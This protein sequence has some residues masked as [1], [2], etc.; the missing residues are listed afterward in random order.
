M[1]KSLISK[2][3]LF[4]VL[5][6]WVLLTEAQVNST[7]ED[8]RIASIKAALRQKKRPS[9][10]PHGLS[11]LMKGEKP[12]NYNRMMIKEDQVFLLARCKTSV[13]QLEKELKQLGAE[14]RKSY[15]HTVSFTLPIA[16]MEALENCKELESVRFERRPLSNV[17]SVTGQAVSSLGVNT[18]RNRLGLTGEGVKIGVLSVSFDFSETNAAVGI[19]SGDLPGPGNPLGNTTPVRVLS[20][21]LSNN[22]ND[23]GR[24]MIELMHDIAPKAEFSFYSAFN[25]FFDFADGIRALAKDG[26][27]II[28]DDVS[29]PESPFFQNGAI[30]QAVDEVVKGGVVYLSSAGNSGANSY[31]SDYRNTIVDSLEMH[32]FDEGPDQDVFQRIEIEDNHSFLLLSFQWDQPSPFYTDGPGATDPRLLT[33]LDLFLFNAETGDLIFQASEANTDN[34][35]EIIEISIPDSVRSVDLAIVKVSGPDPQ[36]I[37]WI[38]F[39]ESFAS[40]EFDTQSSTIIGH[41]N[42]QRGIAVGAVAFFTAKGFNGNTAST[43]NS[44]SSTGGTLIRINNDGSRRSNPTNTIKPDICATDGINNTFFGFDLDDEIGGVMVEN[45]DLPNFFGTSAASPNAAAVV[46]LML[47]ANPDLTPGEIKGLLRNTAEDMDDPAT[48]GFDTGYDT[49]TGFGYLNANKAVTQ[50]IKRIGIAPLVL[51][52]L[53]TISPD[54]KLRWRIRNPNPFNVSYTFEINGTKTLRRAKAGDNFITTE[55]S[56]GSNIAFITWQNENSEKQ[57]LAIKARPEACND[58]SSGMDISGTIQIYP[59]PVISDELNL[60]FESERGRN[61]SIRIFPLSATNSDKPIMFV[62]LEVKKGHNE[63]TIDVSILK[64]GVYVLHIGTARHK[65]MKR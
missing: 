32:D 54:N 53:C 29:Y 25:G 8:P 20:E 4:C 28:V 12:Q 44:F 15:K 1:K 57:Q 37:K 46:A 61:E 21:G 62:P 45:D 65:I 47:Q 50:S 31:E 17:G 11:L 64:S 63:A 30:A 19:A 3:A 39:F 6:H 48:P 27:D 2:I 9:P 55:R 34:P 16:Q 7:N 60:S 51:T 36:R 23:E 40:A 42:A 10:I 41:A 38:D 33:N 26:A 18:F 52:S 49:K 56:P 22:P 13:L 59:N 24:G 5:F 58:T 14:V 35:V 43:I